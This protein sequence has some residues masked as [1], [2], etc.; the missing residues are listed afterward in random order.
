MRETIYSALLTA[1]LFTA[2]VFL[3]AWGFFVVL[4]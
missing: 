4:H 1:V 3:C 2:A